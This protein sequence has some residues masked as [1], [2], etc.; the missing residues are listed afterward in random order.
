MKRLSRG[1][2]LCDSIRSD[3]TAIDIFLIFSSQGNN[4]VHF[5][6]LAPT[7]EVLVF[8]LQ[9]TGGTAATGGRLVDSQNDD[10]T[11]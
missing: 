9:Q 6:V 3:A 2:I 1:G 11:I 5:A 4:P 7:N 10:G 8:L